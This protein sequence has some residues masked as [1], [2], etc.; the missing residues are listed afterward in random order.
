[1]SSPSKR[2]LE[3]LA[4]DMREAQAEIAELD[5][6]LTD[7]QAKREAKAI[8]LESMKRLL[9]PMAQVEI[10]LPPQPDVSD[11]NGSA[12]H[13]THG[14]F[15][16]AIRGVLRDATRGMR[17]RDVYNALQARGAMANYSG[18]ADPVIRTSTELYRMAKV[19]QIKKRGKLYYALETAQTQ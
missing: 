16:G 14:A 5:A 17:T 4:Q 2:A 18:K 7:L 10:P 13:A 15:R 8:K 12:D 11:A 9:G 3:F 6:Q 1:M 19:G